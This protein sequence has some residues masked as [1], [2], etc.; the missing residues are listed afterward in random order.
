MKTVELPVAPISRSILLHNFHDEPIR[1]PR[2]N[3]VYCHLWHRDPNKPR[4]L[5]RIQ[6]TLTDAVTFTIPNQLS[7]H[8]EKYG[9]QVGYHLYEIHI[10]R[11]CQ[12][13]L[14]QHQTGKPA[15][16]AIRDFLHRHGVSED[17]FSVETAYKRWQRWNI[18][19]KRQRKH[20]QKQLQNSEIIKVRIP[21]S[22]ESMR[23][24][25]AHFIFKNY[26]RFLLA[27]GTLNENL[28][29]KARIYFRYRMMHQHVRDICTKEDLSPATVYHHIQTFGQKLK[30]KELIAY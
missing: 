22:E 12:Y 13:T 23:E 25:L 7:E 29:T 4:Q 8:L 20:A 27:D 6:N 3:M 1:P 26:S 18:S 16:T 2:K 9:Y 19:R 5:T 24:R 28:V 21:E 15:M 17:D 11:M 14:A 10:D 30:L